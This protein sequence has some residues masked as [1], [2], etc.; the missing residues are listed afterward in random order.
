MIVLIL[1]RVSQNKI[2]NVIDR[3]LCTPADY[4][5][6]VKNIPK[7]LNVDYKYELTK[8]F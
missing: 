1:F 8:I 7:N 5:I 6:M 2:D 4:T 3:D